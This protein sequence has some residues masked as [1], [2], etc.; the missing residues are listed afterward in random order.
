LKSTYYDQATIAYNAQDY[1]QALKGYYQCLKEDWNSFEPGDAGLL[2]HRIG[3]CLIKMRQ[4]KE[5]AASYQKALQ[6]ADYQEKTSI[7]V[8]LATT[9]NGIGKYP[10][11]ISYFNKALTDDDYP[12]PYRAYMGLGTAYTK[13]GKHIEAGTAFRSAALDE[14][15]PNPVKA[16][17]SL[18]GA[19]SALERPH[20]AIE[21]YLAILD[22]KVTGASLN[23]TL[24]RLGQAYVAAGRYK[25]A[26]DTF[27]D[28]LSQER[29]SLSQEAYEDYQKARM[30]L[31]FSNKNYGDDGYEEK[32][33]DLIVQEADSYSFYPTDGLNE[34]RGYGAGN[35]PH[36]GDTGFFTATDDELMATGKRQLKRERKLRHTGLKIFVSIL[37]ILLLA[38]GTCVFAYTQGFG[39]PSQ[40]KVIQDFFTAYAAD[41]SIE[42]YWLF[43]KDEDK[44]ALNR[45]LDGVARSSDITVV[46]LDSNMTS[47]LATVDVK[48]PDGGVVHYRVHM[49][50]DFISWKIVGIEL[51]FA[52]EK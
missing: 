13:L 39:I 9:L 16:L 51:V 33:P 5:A 34:S 8:N 20:D 49:A 25:D 30:A 29:F 32:L 11:A 23:T 46:G 31:G 36:P 41:E 17:M 3:N 21:A 14:S 19:F 1:P 26:L 40:D 44:A 50:R 42:K 6:D 10:E 35:V 28:V 15:N 38:L 45:W 47:S 52:S 4:F 7:H 18:G 27:E 43:E 12:T 48:L 37:V 24:E 2:Y 22:F